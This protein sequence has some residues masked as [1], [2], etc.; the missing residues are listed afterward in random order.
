MMR[1][2]IV[3]LAVALFGVGTVFA[4]T[5]TVNQV[6]NSFQPDDLSIS[7]GDTVEWVH[8]A[9][10]HTVTSGTGPTDPDVGLLLDEPLTAAN[11]LVTFT[12]NDAGDV[13]YFCDPHFL[14]GMVGI[15]RVLPPIGAAEP[16]Q[17]SSWSRVKA[18]YR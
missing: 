12:F 8:S 15:I 18:L 14:F 16:A 17:A 3:G 11:P 10:I 2:L 4:A 9:G 5:H 6:G 7:V 13:P 1:S